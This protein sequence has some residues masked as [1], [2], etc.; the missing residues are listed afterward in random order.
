MQVAEEAFPG[1]AQGVRSTLAAVYDYV[2]QS[3][4]DTSSSSSPKQMAKE[5][6]IC[7]D[8]ASFPTYI[9]SNAI[10][11]QELT[12]LVVSSNADFNMAYYPPSNTSDLV[13][14]CQIFAA[15]DNET[16]TTAAMRRYAKFLKFKQAGEDYQSAISNDIPNKG[17]DNHDDMLETDST[18]FNLQTEIPSGPNATLSSADWSGM[19]SGDTARIWE[20]QICRDLVVETGF[21]SD[22]NDNDDA[23]TNT[24]T[25]KNPSGDSI[26]FVPPRPF[27]M[28]W[29]QDHCMARFQVQPQPQRLMSLWHFDASSLIKRASFILFTNGLHDGWAMASYTYNLSET[30][31]AVNIPNGAHHSDLMHEWPFAED[32]DDMIQARENIVSILRQWLLDLK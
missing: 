29:L 15:N 21:G 25:K 9:T 11:A 18:C 12:M 31:V 17:S 14:A 16:T 19:G 7:T 27:N 8:D 3:T 30:I 23:N 26:M 2:S 20:F 6:D 32:T 4:E 10:L 13:Q 28:T 5:L 22:D 1:C 24:N